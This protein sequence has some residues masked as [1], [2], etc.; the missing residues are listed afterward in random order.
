[1]DLRLVTL[2]YAVDVDMC[3]PMKTDNTQNSKK[4]FT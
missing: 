3:S 4:E 2:S 1:M